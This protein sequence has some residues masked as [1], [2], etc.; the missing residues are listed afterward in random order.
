MEW[1]KVGEA[2][3]KFATATTAKELNFEPVPGI[4]RVTITFN[5]SDYTP[6]V[7]AVAGAGIGYAISRRDRR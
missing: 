5:E 7:L 2:S 1:T 3:I 6:I 4:R